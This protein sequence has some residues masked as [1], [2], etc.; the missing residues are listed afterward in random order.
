MR[1]YHA[2]LCEQEKQNDS[3]QMTNTVVQRNAIILRKLPTITP[4]IKI[5]KRYR[6]PIYNKSSV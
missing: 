3:T 4:N 2:N 6:T 1:S 5:K